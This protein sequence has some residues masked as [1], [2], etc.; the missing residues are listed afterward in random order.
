M[1]YTPNGY[2]K[3]SLTIV[4]YPGHILPATVLR[5]TQVQITSDRRSNGKFFREIEKGSTMTLFIDETE[6]TAAA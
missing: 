2:N 3:T 5:F 1:H 4:S 6:E